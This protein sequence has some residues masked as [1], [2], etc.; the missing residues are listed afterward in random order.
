MSK[1]LEQLLSMLENS[2]NEAFILFAIAKDYEKYDLDQDAFKYYLQLI[3]IHPDYIGTYYHLG[4]LY[5]KNKQPD[6]ALEI[7]QRG[8][9][10]SKNS[11]RHA[12]AELAASAEELL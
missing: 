7:Y 5:E 1:R 8:M 11:D 9:E 6:L 2:P 10:L 12:Y 3:D 4:K